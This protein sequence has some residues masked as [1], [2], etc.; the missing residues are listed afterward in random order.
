MEK[1]K[2]EDML[3]ILELNN[4]IDKLYKML[5]E[6][7]LN[8][9][10]DSKEYQE[11][12]GMIRFAR[13]RCDYYFLKHPLCDTEMNDFIELLMDL[14]RINP[15][16]T[17]DFLSY[18]PNTRIRRFIEHNT[19]LATIYHQDTAEEQLIFED[20]TDRFF[21][22]DLDLMS[23]DLEDYDEDDLE[24]EEAMVNNLL[25]SNSREINEAVDD[26]NQL[27]FK[28]E[29]HIFI[30]YLI[31]A[32]NNE[33]NMEV[34]KK[35]IETK[36]RIIAMVRNIEDTFLYNTRFENINYDYLNLSLNDMFRKNNNFYSDY[37]ESYEQLIGQQQDLLL[38]RNKEKYDN[39]DDY[40]QD[41][42]LGISLQTYIS[43]LPNDMVRDA[44][45]EDQQTAIDLSTSK[46][47]KKVLRKSLK[48]N[49]KYVLP[50]Q[51]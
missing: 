14:N 48:L 5:C 18:I 2:F 8:G 24:A 30:S 25:Q 32:I 36:Y 39:I 33:K 35:L 42:L 3:S 7:E 23:F 26:Y 21:A 43:C 4:S 29:S 44:I 34:K 40:V 11:Y 22:G 13:S 16:Q 27:K 15:N 9:Q 38:D 6:L 45:I 31:D 37:I 19:E 10:M 20:I 12:V 50:Q 28:I 51:Q 47:D 1:K 17:M 49:N 46:I 41:I